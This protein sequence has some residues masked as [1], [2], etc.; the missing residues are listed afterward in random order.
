MSKEISKRIR[1]TPLYNN[2]HFCKIWCTKYKSFTWLSAK[3]VPT[4]GLLFFS[5]LLANMKT[6]N[7]IEYNNM[8]FFEIKF[9][10][11]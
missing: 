6:E 4:L 5:L 1:I 8:Q 10:Y 3:S 11:K 2:T 9:A 7:I